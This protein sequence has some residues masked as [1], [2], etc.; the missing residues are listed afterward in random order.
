L[1]IKNN[2]EHLAAARR[3]ANKL[4]ALG[5]LMGYG[6]NLQTVRE[7]ALKLIKTVL[8]LKL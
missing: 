3:F 2:P 4:E 6:E 8:R 5:V 1:D 7:Q